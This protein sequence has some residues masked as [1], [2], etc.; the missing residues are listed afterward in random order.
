MKNF[1]LM[2]V[3]SLCISSLMLAQ[4][5]TVTSENATKETK[6]V[7]S[8]V[9]NK[10]ADIYQVMGTSYATGMSTGV[11]FSSGGGYATSVGSSSMSGSNYRFV[12]QTPAELKL[13][14]GQ[15]K[16]SVWNSPYGSSVFTVSATGG[17]QY[18]D[19][20][21]GS[22]GLYVGGVSVL[23]VGLGVGLGVVLG[24]ILC[25]VDSGIPN[26][27]ARGLLGAG[28]GTTVAGLAAGI[29]MMVAGKSKVTLLRIEY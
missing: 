16:L 8:A 18:W 19:V 28:I 11:A 3:V 14:S 15:L 6:I 25:A 1:F 5:L 24:S 20:K 9:K 7:F 10:S 23:S 21:A 17:T 13:D 26:S 4:N 27:I 22:P 29:P 12:C 2:A